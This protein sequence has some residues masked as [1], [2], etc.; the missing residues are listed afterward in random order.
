MNIDLLVSFLRDEFDIF[1]FFPP[2]LMLFHPVSAF[3]TT[4]VFEAAGLEV[5]SEDGY[6]ITFEIFNGNQVFRA[7]FNVKADTRI[8]VLNEAREYC[9]QRV[10]DEHELVDI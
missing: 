2:Q 7:V 8:Q 4:S 10:H 9:I 3:V 5:T 1:L 6:I